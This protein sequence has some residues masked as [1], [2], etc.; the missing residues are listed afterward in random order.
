MYFISFLYNTRKQKQKRTGRLM[1]VVSRPRGTG[2]GTIKLQSENDCL[3]GRRMCSTG[4]FFSTGLLCCWLLLLPWLDSLRQYVQVIRYYI[5]SRF[6]SIRCDSGLGLAGLRSLVS[7]LWARSGLLSADDLFAVDRHTSPSP[8]SMSRPHSLSDSLT[9][10]L[11]LKCTQVP[12]YVH[13]Q[14]H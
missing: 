12:T 14:H 6:D 9:H 3:N 5:T 13:T 10:K 4:L 2:T 11:T 7:S 8:S 1:I